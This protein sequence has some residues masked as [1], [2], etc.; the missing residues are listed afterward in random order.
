MFPAFIG[1]KRFEEMGL[2]LFRNSA[3]SVPDH[4]VDLIVPD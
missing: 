2:Y 3:A 1:A 4:D